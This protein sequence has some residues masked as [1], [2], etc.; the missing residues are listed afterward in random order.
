[1]ADL[2]GT[3]PATPK[4]LVLDTNIWLDWLVF[5]DAGVTPIKDAV[6]RGAASVFISAPC[7]AELA[8]VLG[9]PLSG[10]ALNAEAQAAALAQCRVIARAT[11]DHTEPHAIAALP[12][13]EDPDDQMFLELARDCRA[14]AL[15][16]KDRDLL[17]LATRKVTPLPF[18]I[19]TPREFARDASLASRI[20]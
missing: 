2:A 6:A 4:R 11:E 17:V 20:G 5:D 9:Y 18:R 10:R 1:M 13:C 3:I 19:L 16:T 7:E 15:I 14:D 12:R 8:R